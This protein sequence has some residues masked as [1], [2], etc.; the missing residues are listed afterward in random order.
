MKYASL[1]KLKEIFGADAQQA[2]H[3]LE[4][5]IDPHTFESVQRLVD[6]SYGEHSRWLLKMVALNE[7]GEFAGVESGHTFSYLNA[8]DMYSA[9]LIR[10]NDGRYR[11]MCLGDILEKS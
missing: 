5:V 11:V 1:K 6:Q 2:R 7:L 8:G 10:F 9:T 3:I 4:G